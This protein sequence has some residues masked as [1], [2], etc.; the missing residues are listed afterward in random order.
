MIMKLIL[1]TNE[2]GNTIKC[3]LFIAILIIIAVTIYLTSSLLKDYHHAAGQTL[4]FPI[5][6]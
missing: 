3:V 5:K 2:C 1:K 4:T 6:K